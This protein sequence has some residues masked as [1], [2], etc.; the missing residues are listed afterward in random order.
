MDT[1]FITKSRVRSSQGEFIHQ[2]VFLEPFILDENFRARIRQKSK[3]V[4]NQGSL[5]LMGKDV[6]L[7]MVM[8]LSSKS[9]VEKIEFVKV[10]RL[11]MLYCVIS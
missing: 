3:I 1:V 8:L 7:Y 4:K 10:T 5:C 9:I 6:I 2:S 11:E